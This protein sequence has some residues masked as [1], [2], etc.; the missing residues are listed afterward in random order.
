MWAELQHL[1]VEQGTCPGSLEEATTQNGSCLH[2]CQGSVS[3]PSAGSV[4]R[5][6]RTWVSWSRDSRELLCQPERD[7]GTQGHE[8]LGRSCICDRGK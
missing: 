4:V 6:L 3:L 1:C 2:V 7:G 5:S 8:R